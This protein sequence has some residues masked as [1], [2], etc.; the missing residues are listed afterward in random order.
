MSDVTVTASE[1]PFSGKLSNI[2]VD[3]VRFAD[4]SQ[5]ERE[6]VEHPDAVAVVA[7]DAQGR[8]LLLRQYRHP[9]GE[10]LL[11]LPAGK[12]DRQGEDPADAAR[13]EL[14]EETGWSAGRLDPLLSFHNSAGWTDEGTT[15]YLADDLRETG[16]PDGFTAAHEE[17]D[18]EV[19]WVP[20]DEAVAM[21]A[22]GE[23]RDAKTVIGILLTRLQRGVH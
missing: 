4:G 11:E 10:R 21:V 1:R 22:A 7:L 16:T 19:V 20:L 13:R 3:T 8:V 2:R 14:E 23:I 9:V 17:A 5:A 18:M 15:L 12:L 6:I